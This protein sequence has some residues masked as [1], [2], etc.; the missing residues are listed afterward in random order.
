MVAKWHIFALK[1][2][3]FFEEYVWLW[4]GPPPAEWRLTASHLCHTPAYDPYFYEYPSLKNIG[5][6]P[7]CK[8]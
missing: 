3:T 5:A 8:C 7:G 4:I 2:Q 1:C 6:V